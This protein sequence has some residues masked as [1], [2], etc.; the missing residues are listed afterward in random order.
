LAGSRLLDVV[1]GS[2]DVGGAASNRSIKFSRGS[3]KIF[4]EVFGKRR[5]F[6]WFFCGEDVVECVV[7]VVRKPRCF[8]DGKIRHLFHIYFG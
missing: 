6:L 3:L 1:E 2:L 5:R 4:W 8:D 7:N